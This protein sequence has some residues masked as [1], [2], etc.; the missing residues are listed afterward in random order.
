MADETLPAN[1]T[2]IAAQAVAGVDL[3]GT[4]TPTA[5]PDD[6]ARRARGWFLEAMSHPLWA[7][8]IRESDEDIGFYVG[9]EGQWS[10]DGSREDLDR[11][12]AA[13]RAAISVNHIKSIVDV[14]VGFERQNRYDMR[15]VPQGTEDDEDARILSWLLK[16]IQEQTETPETLSEGFK[17]GLIRGMACLGAEID[18]TTDPVSGEIVVE[19]L[20]PG[21]DIIWDPHWRRYDLSD[22]AYV[23]RYRWV[24]VDELVAQ[25]PE[26]RDRILASVNTIAEALTTVT[27][28]RTTDGPARDGYGAT[29]LHPLETTSI[30]RQFFDPTHRRVLI[31]QPWWMEYEPEH[32]VTDKARG[33]VDTF[34][35][36]EQA[37][38]LAASDK[39]N[40]TYVRK[41]RRCVKTGT[42]LA[43]GSITLE[44]GETPYENDADQYPYVPFIADRI[45]DVIMGIVR[46]LKDPQ[47]VENKRISQAVDIVGRYANLRPIVEEGSLINPETMNNPYDPSVIQK[48]PGK[49]DPKFLTPEG[50][51]QIVSML[52]EL[53]QTMKMEPREVSGVN[54]ELQGVKS[55]ATSGIAIARRQ[56][57][58]QVIA[59][60][61]FDNLRRTRKLLGQ[62]LARRIQQSFTTEKVMRL[63]SDTGAPVT[64]RLNP[65]EASADRITNRD[66]YQAWRRQ[67]VEAGRPHILRDV[68]ALKYDVTIAESPTT[69]TARQGALLFLLDVVKQLPMLLKAPAVVDTLLELSDVPNRATIRAQ[70]AQLLGGAGAPAPG[71]PSPPTGGSAVVSPGELLPS[72]GG[73]APAVPGPPVPPVPSP[74][75]LPTAA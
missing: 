3:P 32:L 60:P 36:A 29:N 20:T 13:R 9:G 56:A 24:Q 6:L 25:Y 75:V 34:E 15:A 55:D 35:T 72:V 52:V 8:Y 45:D 39:K 7:N 12:K 48:R 44:S 66:E 14:L 61:Y 11:I 28:P 47:R 69:P 21:R 10:K 43:T 33:K 51:A 18:Y 58:G 70:V 40:L 4:G 38:T 59:T 23:I 31:L 2:S 68:K 27:D 54:S 26:L 37:R 1:P 46:N 65:V 42:V 5:S 74:A 67:E 17:F 73:P 49:P 62:R 22:A 64:V 63:I 30:E 16:F 53:S 71:P 50:L 41:L 19:V 57:Q